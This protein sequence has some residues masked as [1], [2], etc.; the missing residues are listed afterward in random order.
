MYLYIVYSFHQKLQIVLSSYKK[1]H[2][3]RVDRIDILLL[4]P[5][6]DYQAIEIK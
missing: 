4:K 3:H 6:K 1:T 5:V 2:I